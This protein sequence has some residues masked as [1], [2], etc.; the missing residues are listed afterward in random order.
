MFKVVSCAL[1]L[2]VT[3]VSPSLCADNERP[4]VVIILADDMGY[5][6][7]NCF[8]PTKYRTPNLDKLADSGMR[9]TS[10]Y[11][12]QPVCTASRAS[13]LTGCYA[14][15]VGLQGALN[16]TSRSGINPDEELLPELLKARGYATGIF[17]KWHLGHR[18]KFHP[19][20][21]GF[22]EFFGLP[23]PNDCDNRY[24]PVV[25]TFPPL[26][27]FDGE[28]VIAEDP[29]QSLFTQQITQR[30]V[31]FINRHQKE[32][33]FLYVA[34]IMP[35][36]PIFASKSFEGRSGAGLY[37]DVIEE[38]D[39]SVGEIVAALK[40]NGLTK[41][42]L[43]VFS[44]DNGPFLSYGDHAGKSGPFRGG[45]LTCFEGGVRMPT[46]A[47]WPGAIPAPSTSDEIVTAMDVLPTIGKLTG[48]KLPDSKIDGQ[49]VWPVLSGAPGA[50]SPHEAFY[51]F[52]DNELHAVRQGRWKLHLAHPYLEVD[53]AP[54]TNRK[55]ANFANMRPESI[56][57]SGLKGVASRHG[58]RIE[59]MPQSLFDLESDVG[60]QNDVSAAHPE[61]VQQLLE[62]AAE[63]RAKLGD[64]LTGVKGSEARPAGVAA[65]P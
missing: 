2:L 24:H 22:D 65:T 36:V 13:L 44:S 63:E 42:T 46:I 39:W 14:N 35:H 5:G 19:F 57:L 58:Y 9:L 40:R 38:V 47:A 6:D 8:T 32:P 34:H 25:R 30:S 21:H 31:D 18:P 11:V 50:R 4:N 10:F 28:K 27:L 55:P 64:T 41:K 61:V 7:V 54:G 48:M 60:E 15:R 59:Q 23:Y 29:D 45:K 62:L 53:G 52:A 37:G 43:V 17:G 3:L 1:L 49:D 51:Y 20:K 12:S 33:F 16:H 26:P 56:Q